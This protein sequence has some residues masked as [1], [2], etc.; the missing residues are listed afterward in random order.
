MAGRVELIV[1]YR[2]GVL[3]ASS[4]EMA[5]IPSIDSLLSGLPVSFV[6]GDPRTSMR[7]TVPIALRARVIEAAA[8]FC[9]VDEYAGLELLSGASR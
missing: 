6:S 7:I 2:K 4:A 9:H 1:T 5:A 8:K 3:L